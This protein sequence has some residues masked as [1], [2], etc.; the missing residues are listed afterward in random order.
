MS[1]SDSGAS[2]LELWSIDSGASILVLYLQARD[3]S[4]QSAMVRD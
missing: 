4:S 2:I 3:I 1:A